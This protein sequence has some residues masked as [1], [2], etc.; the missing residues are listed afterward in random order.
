VNFG[1]HNLTWEIML[2][3]HFG[4]KSSGLMYMKEGMLQN[5]LVVRTNSL[6]GV[7]YLHSA[8]IFSF[9]FAVV[10]AVRLESAGKSNVIEPLVGRDFLP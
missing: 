5:S 10:E 3:E 9:Q 1:G 4:C 7:R 6:S 8:D 2:M